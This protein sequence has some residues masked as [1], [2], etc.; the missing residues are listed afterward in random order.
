[1]I[2]ILDRYISKIIMLATLLVIVIV[3]SVMTLI[4]LLQELKNIGSGDYEIGQAIYFVFL[5]LPNE[6]YHFSP[7]LILL[8]SI[9]GLSI[10]SSYRELAVIRTS[11]F[12][13]NRM[14]ISV[15]STALLIILMMSVIGELFAPRLSYHAVIHKENARNAGQAV[16]TA[17][18]IWFHVDN[19]F[20]HAQRVIDRQL[21]EGVTRYQFDHQHR[22][23]A[24]YFAKTLA[25]KNNQWQMND[26]VKTTFH[27]EQTKSQKYFQIPLNLKFNQTL[28][29]VGLVDADEMSLS[30]LNKFTHYL[31]Q[32][33]L[34]ASEYQY[35]F[36]QRAF[37]PMMSLMMVFLAIPSVLCTLNTATLSRRLMI[38]ILVG[39]IFFI[40][41]AFL[42]QLCVVYQLPAL[43]AALLPL[44]LFAGAGFTLYWRLGYKL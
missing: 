22:L 11:G 40:G 12:S 14:I 21:L 19:N 7:I 1:M 28:L 41:N 34:Q 30:K 25:L 33:G 13:V 29:N 26:V 23:Q 43:V 38:G 31:E 37:Q 10:L 35:E 32:N 39:F 16:V 27:D 9:V 4:M 17:T 36:W 2:S 15:L 44:L 20:I 18:G 5:R 6:L 24:A 8:G 42:G 3:A